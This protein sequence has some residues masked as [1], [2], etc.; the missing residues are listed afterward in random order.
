MDQA[1]YSNMMNG[2]DDMKMQPNP[3]GF[4]NLMLPPLGGGSG[5]FN[6]KFQSLGGLN[7]SQSQD[8][9]SMRMGLGSMMDMSMDQRQ[10]KASGEKSKLEVLRVYSDPNFKQGSNL[11]IFNGGLDT[12]IDVGKVTI[13]T[14]IQGVQ[15]VGAESLTF[16]DRFITPYCRTQLNSRGLLEQSS[17]N[18]SIFSNS[19]LS[20][21]RSQHM[22]EQYFKLINTHMHGQLGSTVESESFSHQFLLPKCYDMPKFREIPPNSSGSPPQLISPERCKQFPDKVLFYIF[23]ST[24]HDKAQVNAATELQSR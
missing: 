20:T 22:M 2:R 6:Q 8:F 23:Y 7:P 14:R 17:E 1:S 5:Q 19:E 12:G 24:P 9:Q 11:S 18:D 10:Q 16:V 15:D 3:L 13:D 21:M 4:N